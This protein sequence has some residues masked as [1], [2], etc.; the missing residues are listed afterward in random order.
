MHLTKDEYFSHIFSTY[1]ARIIKKQLK[2]ATRKS[3]EKGLEF[4]KEF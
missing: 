4:F 1:H 2:K 3:I